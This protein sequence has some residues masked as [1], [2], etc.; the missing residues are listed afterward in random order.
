MGQGLQIDHGVRAVAVVR[1]ENQVA[2]EISGVQSGQGQTIA[3]ASQRGFGGGHGGSWCCREQI[4]E[5]M[6]RNMPGNASA[7]DQKSY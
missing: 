7:L 1:V 3:V 4:M 6:V 2:V 5:Q